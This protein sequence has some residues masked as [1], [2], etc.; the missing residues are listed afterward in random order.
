[1]PFTAMELERAEA[2]GVGQCAP[3]RSRSSDH[4]SVNVR[5]AEFE[6]LPGRD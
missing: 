1:M 2:A 6:P 3:A 5:P 4:D